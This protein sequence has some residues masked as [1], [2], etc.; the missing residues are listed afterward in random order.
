MVHSWN[1]SIDQ[2]LCLQHDNVELVIQQVLNAAW[3]VGI[4]VASENALGCFD[5]QGYNKILENAKPQK[6]PDGRHLI[7]FTYLRLN[8][9]LMKEHNFKEFS[10]FVKR[11]HGKPLSPLKNYLALEP[12]VKYFQHKTPHLIKRPCCTLQVSTRVHF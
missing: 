11:L 6:D 12:V 9:E 3:D 10:R 7:A 8:D 4:S 5:R 1:E 2:S